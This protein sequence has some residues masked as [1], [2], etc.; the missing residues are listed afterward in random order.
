M[1][2]IASLS[3]CCCLL[4]GGTSCRCQCLF[5]LPSGVC[6]GRPHFGSGLIILGPFWIWSLLLKMYLCT[7]ASGRFSTGTI[8]S[9]ITCFKLL[10]KTHCIKQCGN[11]CVYVSCYSIPLCPLNYHCCR[12]PICYIS[13]SQFTSLYS[14][15]VC[16]PDRCS[17]SCDTAKNAPF[18]T[19]G[20]P[21]SPPPRLQKS[22]FTAFHQ[23]S[24][25]LRV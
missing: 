25:G 13:H 15:Y 3:N 18:R 2:F 4:G 5:S 14:I 1:I 7:L 17:D 20:R 22:T 6:S 9:S 11:M 24:F 8:C 23:L 10:S 16:L 12:M 21:L 19:D